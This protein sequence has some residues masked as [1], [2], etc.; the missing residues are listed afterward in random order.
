MLRNLMRMIGTEAQKSAST[1]PSDQA[2]G[3]SRGLAIVSPAFES[4]LQD[5]RR[6]L[7]QIC[8]EGK[9]R[10]ISACRVKSAT[11]I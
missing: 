10:S 4:W 6:R 8:E 11:A 1:S 5:Y 2:S 9:S 3:E 7:E